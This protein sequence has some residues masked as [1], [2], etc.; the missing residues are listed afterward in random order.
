MQIDERGTHTNS[1]ISIDQKR[2]SEVYEAIMQMMQQ[3]TPFDPLSQNYTTVNFAG[4]TTSNVVSDINATYHNTW[5]ID[6]G[7]SDHMAYDLNC[8]A[9][10]QTLKHPLHV[11]LPDGTVKNVTQIG[12]ISLTHK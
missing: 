1:G 4:I 2:V 6:T 5:I 3:Q 10:I 7:A 12:T 9:S 8:F 11:V